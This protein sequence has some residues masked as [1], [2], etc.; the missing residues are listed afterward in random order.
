MAGHA[1]RKQGS[2]IRTVIENNPAGKR[3]LGRPR[4][5]WEN[6]VIKDVKRIEANLQWREEAEDRNR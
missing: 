1:W 3:P 5:R 4:L 2:M 6:C